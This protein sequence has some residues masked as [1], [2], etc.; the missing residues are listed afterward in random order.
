MTI[1]GRDVDETIGSGLTAIPLF[2]GFVLPPEI[3]A[4][5]LPDRGRP[6]R[7]PVGVTISRHSVPLT[8]GP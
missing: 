1:L 3:P 7:G 5:A 6:P 2:A 8:L 4:G